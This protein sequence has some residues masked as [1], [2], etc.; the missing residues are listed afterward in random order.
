MTETE[1][2]TTVLLYVLCLP[3]ICGNTL[4]KVSLHREVKECRNKGKWS[5]R[6]NSNSLVV[7]IGKDLWFFLKATR[8]YPERS[9]IDAETPIRSGRKLMHDDQIRAMI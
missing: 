3:F 1:Q 6:L 7:S 2:N 9:L 4:A 5:T 8:Y